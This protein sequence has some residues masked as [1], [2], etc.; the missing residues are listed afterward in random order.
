M[1][2]EPFPNW[3]SYGP[4]E[5]LTQMNWLK[6][7]KWISLIKRTG[8]NEKKV[9]KWVN[10]YELRIVHTFTWD[11]SV[12]ILLDLF[13]WSIFSVIDSPEAR[14]EYKYLMTRTPIGKDEV[15]GGEQDPDFDREIVIPEDGM[16]VLNC[17]DKDTFSRYSSDHYIMYTQTT[18]DKRFHSSKF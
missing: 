5:L 14:G 10:I 6:Y 9:K 16:P 7:E 1:S 3:Y 17:I 15:I 4:P 12:S 8:L 18:A 11:I 2:S 13:V